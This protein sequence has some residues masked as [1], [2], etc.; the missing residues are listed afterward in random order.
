MITA[1]V[2]RPNMDCAATISSSQEDE[3]DVVNHP[4][5]YADKSIEVIEYIKDT[6]TPDGYTDYCIG[7]VIKYVSRWRKK[8][9]VEDLRKAQVY[10]NWAAENAEK[11][12]TN[13]SI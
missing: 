7:N 10:L 11:I 5:H 13:A 2:P 12:E 9:G 6:L 4:S 8:G 3:H 1:F